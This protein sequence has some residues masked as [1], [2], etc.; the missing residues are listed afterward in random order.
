MLYI[1]GMTQVRLFL[2]GQGEWVQVGACL[3]SEDGINQGYGTGEG[4]S[5]QV[6]VCMGTGKGV[7]N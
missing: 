4:V 1:K 7:V 2:G 5:R 3:V 6:K